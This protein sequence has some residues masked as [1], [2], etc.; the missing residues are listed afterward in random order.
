ML[1][2]LVLLLLLLVQQRWMV[3]MGG[4]IWRRPRDP[5]DGEAGVLERQE[6]QTNEGMDEN[7]NS[8]SHRPSISVLALD[9][10]HFHDARSIHHQQALLDVVGPSRGSSVVVLDRWREVHTSYASCG[11]YRESGK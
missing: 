5:S 6:Q 11:D 2:L 10:L 4:M 7:K 8:N 1:L 9:R 3:V